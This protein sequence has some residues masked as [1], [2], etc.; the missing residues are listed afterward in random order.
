MTYGECENAWVSGPEDL[1]P[2]GIAE[3]C[4]LVRDVPKDA[5]L[6]HAD[7]KIPE[8]RLVDGSAP[9]RPRPSRSRRNRPRKAR[10]GLFG[11][12]QIVR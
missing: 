6:T 2:M 9:S 7:V 4:T 10:S 11:A 5:A 12:P 1:L 8:G 3:G